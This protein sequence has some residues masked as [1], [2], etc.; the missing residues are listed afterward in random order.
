MIR[1]NLGVTAFAYGL[2]CHRGRQ[3]LLT[4]REISSL[5]FLAVDDLF[6]S[7]LQDSVLRYDLRYF[8]QLFHHLRHVSVHHTFADP[9]RNPLLERRSCAALRYHVGWLVRNMGVHGWLDGKCFA[10]NGS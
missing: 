3:T 5:D 4:L 6:H 9:F 10:L 2:R 1:S 8:Q 7:S